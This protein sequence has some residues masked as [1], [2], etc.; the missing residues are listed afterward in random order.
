MNLET[1]AQI[2]ETANQSGWQAVWD[3]PD[4]AAELNR[5]RRDLRVKTA[6]KALGIA[7]K[8]KSSRPR[9]TRRT[10]INLNR[11]RALQ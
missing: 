9:W 6:T 2:R 5:I 1:H 11:A 10:L 3:N 4:M 8:L 7:G